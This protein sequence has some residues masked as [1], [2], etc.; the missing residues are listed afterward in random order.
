MVT[1]MPP[2]QRAAALRQMLAYLVEPLQ[3]AVQAKDETIAVLL[4]DRLTTVFRNDPGSYP[5][6]L[7]QSEVSVLAYLA[8]PL[9][10]AVQAKDE[11]IAVLL[12]DRLT[13]VL[14]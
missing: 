5:A 11:T 12:M 7:L 13:T 8:G 4:V 3:Q 9:Q 6:E 14:K 1:S 2:E 10:Q